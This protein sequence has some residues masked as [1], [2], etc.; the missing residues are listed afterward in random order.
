[1]SLSEITVILPSLNPD[2]KLIGTVEGLIRVGFKDIVLINDGSDEEHTKN[3]PD[4]NKYPQCTIINHWINR[5]KGAGLK[6][7]FAF[8][9]KMRPNCRGVV[10][11]DGDGQH[12]PED[13]A[14]CAK[15][16][17]D[18][19]CVILGA[20]NFDLEGIPARSVFGNKM[21]SFVLKILCGMKITDTQ[22]GLRAI[23]VE[24]LDTLMSVKGDRFEYETNMLLAFK[25]NEINYAENPIRTVYI[26]ENKTSHFNPFKDSVRIYA[27]ILKYVFSSLSATVIDLGMFALLF[28][29]LFPDKITNKEICAAACSV[30]ARIV[31]SAYN[32]FINFRFVFSKKKAAKHTLLKYYLLAVVVMIISGLS[33][34]GLTLALP[35]DA[36]TSVITFAKAVID[37]ILFILTFTVQREWVFGGKKNK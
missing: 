8:V 21:T 22:T 18:E 7:A 19:Q 36:D 27:Q 31:S 5:G 34:S 9:K 32:Y 3:F 14:A 16:M 37:T 10:T 29:L 2:E 15:R 35:D 17:L 26:E 1:M 4:S 24:H 25:D 23:P 30:M 13:V 6:T 11:V 12:R 20:R 33:T 28:A